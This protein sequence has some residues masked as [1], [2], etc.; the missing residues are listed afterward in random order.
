[1]IINLQT[2]SAQ[3]SMQV[4]SWREVVLK[5][6]QEAVSIDADLQYHLCFFIF[7]MSL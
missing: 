2:A 3:T 6:F 7:H 5:S 1:L 4:N